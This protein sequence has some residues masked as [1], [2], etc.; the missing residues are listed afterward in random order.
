MIKV[1]DFK[2]KHVFTA[3]LSQMI[4]NKTVVNDEKVI[5][6]AIQGGKL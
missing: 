1:A 4:K 5:E 3:T 2:Q 6:S